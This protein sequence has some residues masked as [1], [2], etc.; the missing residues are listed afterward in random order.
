MFD[1]TDFK[2]VWNLTQPVSYEEMKKR[3]K[4]VIYTAV[5]HEDKCDHNSTHN[6][7]CNECG[8]DFS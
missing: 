3:S 8:M 7:A 2:Q 6:L 5:A 4:T 1:P